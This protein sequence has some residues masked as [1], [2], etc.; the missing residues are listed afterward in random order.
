MRFDFSAYTHYGDL[1]YV[2]RWDLMVE[3]FREQAL[4]CEQVGITTYWF[5]EHHFAA[6]DGWNNSTPNPVLMAMDLVGWIFS[7]PRKFLE[8]CRGL[9]E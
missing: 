6:I 2:R 5:P 1:E 9:V 3:E 8:S 4:L 7:P